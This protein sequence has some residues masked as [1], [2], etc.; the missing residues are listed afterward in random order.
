MNLLKLKKQKKENNQIYLFLCL[1]KLAFVAILILLAVI[2]VNAQGDMKKSIQIINPRPDFAL[3][4]RLDKGAGAT[5]V[6]GERIRILFRSTRNAYVAI[7]GYDSY[8]NIRL[9]FPNQYQKNH[10]I[11]A[12]KQYSIDGIIDPATKSGLE[13]VQGFAT[14]EPVI[15]SRELERLIE[16]ELFPKL[17]E[18]ITR[19][20]QRIRGILAALPSQRWVSS[21]ILHY[22]VVERREEDGQ[23]R[24]NSI[25]EGAD[26]YLNDRYAGKT[27]LVLEH[28]RVGEYLARVELPG[29][30]IWTRT[31]QI[32][33][34]RTAIVNA[35]LVSIQRYGSVAIRCNED[36]A[37]IF[38]DGQY[39]G[40]T[41][42]N[43]NVLLEQVREGFHDI[44]ITLSGYRE[45]TQRV[46]VKSNQ[47][48][49]LTVNLDRITR[50]GS[51]EITCDVD[52]AQIYLDGKYQR[53]T[54]I[55]RSVTISNIQEGNYEIR[56]TKDGY[57]DYI[58]TVRIYPD[59][60]Y[61]LNVIMRPVQREGNIS[62]YCNENNAKIFVNGTYITTTTANKAK[63]LDGF[64][65]GM[66]EITLIKDG[67]R[68]WLDEIWVYPG[69]TTTVYTNLVKIGS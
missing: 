2:T 44:R 69:E 55:N 46:E 4:L 65:E 27:P 19:F 22:Q 45:W 8:G 18:G 32:N 52:N 60:T 35:N 3:S 41:E 42:K 28:I 10:F 50:R 36:N 25:P 13:Y 40:L 68:T 34:D 7:F 33:P 15:I 14:T 5:Y 56:I 24:L 61:R 39:K 30:Q 48:I 16:R 37:S 20:T 63:I 58:T 66:Y 38:L 23:L 49:Q 1:G 9:L 59:Q 67:Y 26:V 12:N 62:I 64:K 54:S 11:D 6:P 29:Y 47:R 53:R 31:I 51:L 57:H 17:G 21:E 43:R